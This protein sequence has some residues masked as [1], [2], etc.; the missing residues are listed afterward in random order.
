MAYQE[1]KQDQI[2]KNFNSLN[3]VFCYQI[4]NMKYPQLKFK[5]LRS[6]KIQL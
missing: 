4:L 2:I 5:Y 6:S 1:L 3:F